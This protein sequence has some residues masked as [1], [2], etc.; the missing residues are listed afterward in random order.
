MLPLLSEG[1][2]A[3][4]V[5]HRALQMAHIRTA[6]SDFTTAQLRLIAKTLCPKRLARV[7]EFHHISKLTPAEL[8]DYVFGVDLVVDMGEQVYAGIDTTLAAN[9]VAA[10]VHKAMGLT[11]LR[12]KAGIRQFFVVHIVGDAL[13]PDPSVLATSVESLWSDIC[14]AF[15][16]K[17]DR[18]GVIR[19]H[20][21]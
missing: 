3:E 16:G 10:K 4:R 18:V 14:E 7:A 11:K 9:E 20:V 12:A 15:N 17:P 6:A 8:L 19:F 1:L 5:V 21:S 2:R 13:N